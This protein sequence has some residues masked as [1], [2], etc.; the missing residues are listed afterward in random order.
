MPLTRQMPLGAPPRHGFER[1]RLGGAGKLERA[2]ALASPARMRR[3]GLMPALLRVSTRTALSRAEPREEKLLEPAPG[4]EP[5]SSAWKAE[6]QPLYHTRLI[7]AAAPIAGAG[8]QTSRGRP[9]R[10]GEPQQRRRDRCAPD[11]AGPAACCAAH[12]RIRA[13]A[14]QAASAGVSASIVSA[15]RIAASSEERGPRTRLP[16]WANQPSPG[17]RT[18]SAPRVA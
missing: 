10:R 4:I 15:A 13:V 14:S 16:Q 11:A 9:T 17:R 3:T 8:H 1:P 6:A 2:V 18:A 7:I 12:W 5:G